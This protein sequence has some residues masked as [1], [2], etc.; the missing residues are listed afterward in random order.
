M[1]GRAS[2]AS[3]L[4]GDYMWVFGGYSLGSEPFD[5]FIRYMC[6]YMQGFLNNYINTNMA[7]CT[8]FV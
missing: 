8:V 1:Q 3:A 2:H 6:I 7:V 4:L 5:N